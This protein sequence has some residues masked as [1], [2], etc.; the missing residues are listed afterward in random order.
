MHPLRFKKATLTHIFANLICMIG[1]SFPNYGKAQIEMIHTGSY[2]QN[3]DILISSG[4][5]AW[6]DNSTIP[7]WYWQYQFQD[8]YKTYSATDGTDISTGKKSFGLPGNSDRAMGIVPDKDRPFTIGIALQNKSSTTISQVSI[9]YTGEQWRNGGY[10]SPQPLLFGYRIVSTLDPIFTN[11]SDWNTFADLHFNSP[12]YGAPAIILNG[13]LPENSTVFKDISLPG[14]SIPPNSYLQ[15]RWHKELTPNKSHDLAIDDVTIKWVVPVIPT[16]SVSPKSL[17]GLNGI[18]DSIVSIPKQYIL[19]GEDLP[20]GGNPIVITAPINYEISLDNQL[21]SSNCSLSYSTPILSP[22][23]VYVR[24]ASSAKA[25]NY[26]NDLITHSIGGVLLS[27]IP[28]SGS[29]YKMNWIENF[30]GGTQTENST[31]SISC[32][33]G[34]WLFKDALI[35]NTT[36]DY[37][38]GK[39]SA[40]LQIN[41]IT[42]EAG[43]ITMGFDKMNGAGDVLVS[44]SNYGSDT[45][46][47][48]QLQ[49]SINGGSSWVNEG[50][51]ILCTENPEMAHFTINK[52]GV[53]RFRIIQSLTSKPSAINID[54]V[55]ISDYGIGTTLL[56]TGGISNDWD[57]AGNWAGGVVP[58]PNSDVEIPHVS[59]NPMCTKDVSLKSLIIRTG[60]VLSLKAGITFTVSS[61][62]SFEGVKCMVLKS[63][64]NHGAAASFI[65][66]GKISGGGTIMIE[67]FIIKYVGE[68]DG[69]HF[70]SSPVDN[71]LISDSFKPS[72][73]D[74]L[75]GYRESDNLWINQKLGSNNLT[76]FNNGEGYLASYYTEII[77]S[78]SGVPNNTDIK[79]T[80]LTLTDNRGWH[81]LG[82]PF[83][84]GLTW[85]TG[86]N[87]VGINST[88]KILNSGGT[89]SDMEE[90][91]IIPSMNGF[92]IRAINNVNT[93]TIPVAA[94]IHAIASGWKSTKT[95]SAKKIKLII[96]STTDNTYAETKVI[97]N[98]KAS[99]LFNAEYDSPFLEGMYGTP[100]FYSILSNGQKLSTNS[101]PS[102]SSLLFNLQFSKGLSDE[103]TLK[104]EISDD[105]LKTST[106]IVE[107]KLNKKKYALSNSSSFTFKSDSSDIID[108]F[109]LQIDVITGLEAAIDDKCFT[110]YSFQKTVYL[111]ISDLIKSGNVAVYD[112]SGKLVKNIKLQSSSLEFHLA[113]SGIY[114]V[115]VQ[116]NGK[117]FSRKIRVN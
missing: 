78:I 24:L 91:E 45:G 58:G 60:A 101:V 19:S 28:V 56:W 32:T 73:D 54:D 39:K 25:G 57:T 44:Y 30:E 22:Q 65:C 40:R 63:P 115:K 48:W 69:W 55:A 84:S 20:T 76:S 8:Q 104:A 29:V 97:L 41:S 1:I 15:L 59:N 112:I 10:S 90:G 77:R 117:L 79:F 102:A 87:T 11:K 31:E 13:N 46:G 62:C 99:T 86:W 42:N 82:N 74:D 17:T 4:S 12:K 85:F 14:I 70:I 100:L 92:F 36:L 34:S 7:G 116:H 61:N 21:F 51:E 18:Q 108:R 88:A 83:T 114:I 68:T 81:L 93:I 50:S 66:N 96:S 37:K 110:L 80:N 109:A 113:N 23:K 49:S 103:Y 52:S 89:Y 71:P 72:V 9:S 111:K 75:F 16:L 38:R 2:S 47:K 6:T 53:I 98:D 107:D 3:F 33:K 35:G 67:R 94:R 95:S 105:W 5:A 43:S 27:T 64:N 106:F 26:S